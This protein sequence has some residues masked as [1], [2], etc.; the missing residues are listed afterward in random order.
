MTSGSS[1]SRSHSNGSSDPVPMVLTDVLDVL[2]DDWLG[3]VH[4]RTVADKP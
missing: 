1:L 4:H 2:G 3:G